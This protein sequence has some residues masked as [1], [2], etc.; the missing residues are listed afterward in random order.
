MRTT[1]LFLLPVLVGL[2]GCL[3]GAHPYLPPRRETAADLQ[4]DPA[5][6]GATRTPA[7]SPLYGWDGSPVGPPPSGTVQRTADTAGHPLE[8]GG[9]SRLVLLDLYQRAVEERDEYLLEV[10]AQNR[11][12]ELAEG[13]FQELSAQHDELAAAFDRLGVEKSDLELENADLAGRLTTAQIR[14]LEAE[15][16]WL[17]AAIE[18]Q[19]E[20]RRRRVAAGDEGRE[21]VR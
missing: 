2:S 3:S 15:K 18:W 14:R 10:E 7:S 13:R 6:W 8:D 11:A 16:A 12:L 20:A 19:R 1:S 4:P 21:D 9:G 17:E 5:G